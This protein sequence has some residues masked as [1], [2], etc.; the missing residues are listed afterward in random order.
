[1]LSRLFFYFF[2]QTNESLGLMK[3]G[4]ITANWQGT[5]CAVDEGRVPGQGCMLA[6]HERST[7][8]LVHPDPVL[9]SAHFSVFDVTDW[10]HARSHHVS[11]PSCILNRKW[12][13][14][15]QRENRK[16]WK[17]A[18]LPILHRQ[19]MSAGW[20]CRFAEQKDQISL[21]FVPRIPST[22]CRLQQLLF[23]PSRA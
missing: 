12:K 18:R 15:A 5:C 2:S 14:E 7:Q 16:K 10:P 1:M 8:A 17:K 4:T 11:R 3:A 6:Q 20:R 23:C 19:Q 21:S 9:P 22:S 13:V